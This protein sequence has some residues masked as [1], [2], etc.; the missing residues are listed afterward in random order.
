MKSFFD[1]RHPWNHTWSS[2]RSHEIKIECLSSVPLIISVFGLNIIKSRDLLSEVDLWD[3]YVQGYHATWEYLWSYEML[4]GG[5][6]ELPIRNSWW[7]SQVYT[8]VRCSSI[9]LRVTDFFCE[10][11]EDL[12]FSQHPLSLTKIH[13]QCSAKS[14]GKREA[15]KPTRQCI[16]CFCGTFCRSLSTCIYIPTS[17][18]IQ[19][20]WHVKLAVKD[21]PGVPDIVP[22]AV[23]ITWKQ[24]TISLSAL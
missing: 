21:E 20:V 17:C 1:K 15:S 7:F 2:I 16:F 4:S 9:V 11:A 12:L 6:P 18:C 8:D 23:D 19:E 10:C 5:F 3:I 13:K 24:K 22:T 14:V